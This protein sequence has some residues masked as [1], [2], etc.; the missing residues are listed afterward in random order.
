MT[1]QTP[2]PFA[3]DLS[4]VS[5]ESRM[6]G[7]YLDYAM[8]VIVGRALPDVRDGLKPV[9]RRILYAM[10]EAGNDWNKPYKKSARIVGDVLGKYHPH[11]Q[12]AVYDSLVRMAQTFS[13]RVPLVSGQGNFGSVDGDNP[14]AMRYTEVRLA[15]V[16]T[17]LLDD[18]DKETVDFIPNYDGA[19]MEPSVLPARFPNLLVNGTAGIAV[20]MATNIPPHNLGEI[21][22]ACLHLIKHPAAGVDELMAHLPAPDFPTGALIHG[23]EGVRAAYRTGRGRVVMRAKTHFEDLDK[24]RQAVI[25][26]ELPYQVNKATLVQR[27]AELVR[28]KKLDG[29]SDL[30][31]ES[32][33]D[34]MR[35]VIELKRGENAEV[36]LNKLYKDTAL[37]DTFSVN[38]VALSDGAPQLM[39]LPEIL[40]HFLSHRREVVVRR[41]LFE[42][43]KARTRAHLLEGYAAAVAN[44]DQIVD[45]IKTSPSPAAAETALLSRR[46]SAQT[47]ADMLARLPDPTLIRPED[48]PPGGLI[49]SGG[50]TIEYQFSP[51]QAKA[52]LDLRLARLTALERE[53]IQSDYADIVAQIIDLL[54][55]LADSD[56]INKLIAVELKE[57]KKQFADPRR[58]EIT[59][60]AGEIDIEQLIAREE[61]VVTLSHRG[62][63][64]R[65]AISDYRIQ[66]R[67]GRG[68]QAATTRE[69]D[70][71]NR[72]FVATTHDYLLIL[73]NRGKAHWKKV[74]EL[75]LASRTSRGRPISGLLELR[76]DETVQTVLPVDDFSGDRFVVIATAQ[77]TIKKTRL[78]AFSRPRRGGIAAIN[79]DPDDR[80]INAAIT[81]DKDSILLLSNVGRAAHFRESALRPIGRSARGVRGMKLPAGAQIVSMI[82]SSPADKNSILI[83]TTQGR[84]KRTDVS[85][86]AIKNRGGMGVLSMRI[87]AVTGEV[88]G[89]TLAQEED[90][91]M[92][93]TDGG[94]LIRTAMQGIRRMR[95]VTQGVR[96]INLDE[97]SRLVSVARIV[98]TGKEGDD[99]D[100][101]LG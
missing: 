83:A 51:A 95:R 1:D 56:K 40:T 60:D 84:G 34:G 30:R 28:E 38:M 22:D 23:V 76:D 65:Q 39:T 52:I 2:P 73:T 16:S 57:I 64:K 50:K 81:N 71:I 46:W 10:H 5:L 29:V 88:I 14:A 48:A 67:G 87:N 4:T 32:D 13:M 11:G 19:E 100:P 92:L 36:I 82:I 97:G 25:V 70:F 3:R 96:L 61:M 68:K 94:V 54:A 86:F 101:D 91:L 31:D 53:K 58:S 80:L 6:K 49:K 12:D 44:V 41:A 45:L 21:V 43:R 85:E 37:Q 75:P 69:N 20:G 66:R 17:A 63:V 99:E 42:L 9:H 78:D 62:Y 59:A 26:D 55:L 90:E 33:R 47:V 27:I 79:L 35:I 15:K 72:L 89:A 18:L 77:G 24:S 93:I 8:S 98:D 74:Y 7:A